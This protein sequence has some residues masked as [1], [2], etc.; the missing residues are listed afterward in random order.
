MMQASTAGVLNAQQ[1]LA[2]LPPWPVTLP[3]STYSLRHLEFLQLQLLRPFTEAPDF[4]QHDPRRKQGETITKQ[5]KLRVSGAPCWCNTPST[6][7]PT[8]QT[9]AVVKM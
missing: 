6:R 8:A 5:H 9:Y 1:P 2:V 3:C 4:L 7:G